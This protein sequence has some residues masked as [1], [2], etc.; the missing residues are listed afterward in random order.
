M[1]ADFD[2]RVLLVDDQPIVLAGLLSILENNGFACRTATNGFDA[3]RHLRKT[4]PD[5]II[6]D[7]AMPNMSGFELLS[8][9]RRRFPQIAV[10]VISG[11][12]IVNLQTSGALMNAFFQKGQY[13]PE[14]LIAT[15]HELH[16]SWQTQAPAQG[17]ALAPLWVSRKDETYLVATCG[18]CLR[19]FPVENAAVVDSG[20]NT[21]E[22]PFCGVNVTYAVDSVVVNVLEPLET[23]TI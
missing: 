4:L 1:N 5:V 8:I 10:I 13:T 6:C 11:E 14:E 17:L 12:F 19:S 18:E 7:L 20:L 21:E 22:C 9:I 16:S 3:L 23:M 15:I 2:L